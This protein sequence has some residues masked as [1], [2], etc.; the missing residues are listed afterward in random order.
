MCRI[1]LLVNV[2]NVQNTCLPHHALPAASADF[3][4]LQ[5]WIHHLPPVPATTPQRRFCYQLDSDGGRCEDGTDSVLGRWWSWHRTDIAAEGVHSWCKWH[6]QL[7]LWA[8]VHMHSFA[9]ISVHFCSLDSDSCRLVT[10]M[11]EIRRENS[12]SQTRTDGNVTHLVRTL[13]LL[14]SHKS[15]YFI[16]GV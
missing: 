2:Q 9:F 7:D 12:F 4:I 14:L 10:F 8:F 13:L 15:V 5:T 1:G 6:C 11:L 16:H 3:C